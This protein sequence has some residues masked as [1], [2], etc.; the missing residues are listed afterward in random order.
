MSVCVCKDLSHGVYGGLTPSILSC[1]YLQGASGFK[2]VI[3]HNAHYS[4]GHDASGDLPHT[5]RSHTGTLVECYESA[6]NQS[7]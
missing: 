3:S 1:T 7:T 5:N 6:S 4:F 2:D